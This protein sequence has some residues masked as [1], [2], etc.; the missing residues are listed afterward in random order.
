MSINKILESIITEKCKDSEVALHLS[1]GVYSCCLGFCAEE[2]GK[3]VT[4]Y[5][6]R[7]INKPNPDSISAEAF[8][9]LANKIRNSVFNLT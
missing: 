7:I 6:F 3:T 9:N 4:A 8:R 5:C 2:L 1:G